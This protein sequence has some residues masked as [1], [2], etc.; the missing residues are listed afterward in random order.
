MST[1]LETELTDLQISVLQDSRL[2]SRPVF[3][4]LCSVSHLY[5]SDTKLSVLIQ[6]V[7]DAASAREHGSIGLQSQRQAAF[8]AQHDLR[9]RRL[10][11]VF[12]SRSFKDCSRCVHQPASI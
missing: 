11:L 7:Q 2:L 6:Q 10:S 5:F 9:Q 4:Q 12:I 3:L 8:H 1:P